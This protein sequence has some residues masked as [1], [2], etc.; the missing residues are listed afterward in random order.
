MR[1]EQ[2]ITEAKKALKDIG[3]WEKFTNISAHYKEN[4]SLFDY[5]H[6][7]VRFQHTDDDYKKGVVS[8]LMIVNDLDVLVTF[9]S[10][11]RSEFFLSY[12]ETKMKYYHPTLSREQP[13]L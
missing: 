4:S 6:W 1:K 2:A 9:C 13:D 5:P 10:W 12:D 8:P 3:H 11:E 7:F